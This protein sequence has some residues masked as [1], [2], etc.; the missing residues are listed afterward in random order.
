VFNSK[1]FR[2]LLLNIATAFTSD[3]QLRRELA[4]SGILE[5]DISH[6]NSQ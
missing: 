2:S 1:T 4:I 3:G 5:N 6:Q